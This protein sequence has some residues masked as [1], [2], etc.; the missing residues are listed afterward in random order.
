MAC[1]LPAL[2]APSLL[3]GVHV[4]GIVALAWRARGRRRWHRRSCMA[5]ASWA[6]LA[7]SLLH[8][9]RVA[10]VVGAVALAWRGRRRRR[11]AIALA[12]HTYRGISVGV[13][14]VQGEATAAIDNQ[15]TSCE[16]HMILHNRYKYYQ[17]F[18]KGVCSTLVQW[19]GCA[20]VYVRV[21][22][23][24]LSGA[25]FLGGRPYEDST[26]TA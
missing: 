1:T 13:W 8:G 15:Q 23:S 6:S 11:C 4:A 18:P 14:V 19:F 26:E 5:C 12:W 3:H 10:G 9:V 24:I 25:T 21:A 20:I 16:D 22:G 17:I 2:S 7:P